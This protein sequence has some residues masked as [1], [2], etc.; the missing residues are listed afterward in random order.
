MWLQE[1]AGGNGVGAALAFG[2]G[3]IVHRGVLVSIDGV[4]EL[5][6]YDASSLSP[7]EPGGGEYGPGLLVPEG[8]GSS[9]RLSFDNADTQARGVAF[10]IVVIWSC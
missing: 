2:G 8:E 9:G 6:G 10:W 1:P 4:G 7:Q 3:D 5:M